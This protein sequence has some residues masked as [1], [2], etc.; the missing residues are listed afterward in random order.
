MH[1]ECIRYLGYVN[2]VEARSELRAR[3]HLRAARRAAT[4]TGRGVSY[5]GVYERVGHSSNSR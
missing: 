5:E 1:A 4:T 3:S 2:D